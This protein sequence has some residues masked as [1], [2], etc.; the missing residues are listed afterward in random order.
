MEKDAYGLRLL[1]ADQ[2]ILTFVKRDPAIHRLKLF[3]WSDPIDSLVFMI[4]NWISIPPSIHVSAH[5]ISCLQ[6]TQTTHYGLV[7]VVKPSAGWIQKSIWRQAMKK[8]HKDGHQ[9]S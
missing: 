9:L 5:I 8:V 2:K 3:L 7:V 4:R 6:K 1:Y